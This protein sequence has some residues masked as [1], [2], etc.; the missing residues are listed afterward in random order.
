MTKENNDDRSKLPQ[1]LLD[2][3][4][5]IG[6][7]VLNFRRA[8]VKEYKGQ[9]YVERVLI[10]VEEDGELKVN[11][12]DYE[13]TK[14]EA[15][16]I[17]AELKECDF[18]RHVH[19]T[20]AAAKAFIAAA[21]KA[22]AKD[23]EEYFLLR[24]RSSAKITMI[25]ERHYKEDGTKIFIPHTLW[26]DNK[27]RSMECSGKLPFWKPREKSG[28]HKLMVHEGGKPARYID[29]LCNDPSP[30][31]KL[32][33]EHHPWT[34][35]LA[36]YEHW[37]M[38]G[39][40]LAAQRS[41]YKEIRT[42][43]FQEIVYV[44]DNDW[45][46][47]KAIKDF[48]ANYGGSMK[49][50]N[51][52]DRFKESFD[53]ADPLPED[54]FKII[55]VNDEERRYWIGPP[56]HRFLIGA[57]TATEIVP[58]PSGKGRSVAVLRDIFAQEWHHT[59]SPEVFIHRS[60]PN[61]LMN[62]AEFNSY[63][64]PFSDVDDVARLLRADFPNK[65]R[66]MHYLPGAPAGRYG[67]NHLGQFFNTY[68]E[69]PI[70][71]IKKRRKNDT[72]P[73]FDFLEMF[74][75]EESDRIEVMRWCATLLARPAIRMTYG[76]LLV[77]EMQGVGK[78]T[79][80]EKILAPLVGIDNV[81]FPS[82]QDIVESQFNSWIAHRRLAVVHEIYQGQSSRA[83]N[84]V[85]SII[86]DHYITVNKKH[87]PTYEIE[88]WMHIVACSN[89]LR[90]LKLAF[91]DRRW[92]VPRITEEQ[93]GIEYWLDLNEW[94]E[95]RNGLEII[96]AW[97]NEWL[98][99]ARP[100]MPGANAPD[101]AAKREMIEESMSPG[102]VLVADLL[103]RWKL[104]NEGKPGVFTTDIA[105]V[106]Y[107]KNALYNGKH[108]DR[109]ERPGTIRKLAKTRGWFIGTERSP[110]FTEH[111]ERA[112][113]LATKEALSKR[114]PEALREEGWEPLEMPM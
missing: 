48:S 64:R 14:E 86:T 43:Q 18:P 31:A 85:K 108:N 46:G 107:I 104:E 33:R 56:L 36:G 22:N 88:N 28:K 26:S 113:I 69:P 94:L 7:E 62:A 17:K 32:A 96:L 24:S 68:C 10:K 49:A 23:G 51:F 84:R 54:L 70:K 53:L 9:Y 114:H 4:R 90:A 35:E 109:L 1:A 97:A 19:A 61:R 60:W 11:R 98:L 25:Q 110:I 83:Y 106:N 76:L 3:Y 2:Y 82:E 73:W 20:E 103:D 52:D 6:A 72:Q 75:P 100:V 39:G 99:D 79:L 95:K 42:E 37:G 13:P 105:L 47:R 44:G 5:R 15:A 74:I 29:W 89:S 38:I 57:T 27:W 71:P 66:I 40:A 67:T 41:D 77:S 80:G 78:G 91:D 111:G 81:S 30:E 87:M 101:S 58:N 63:V 21:A 55:I 50:I 92:Y 8:M 12:K 16:A 45:P 102:M 65:S 59:V 112:R 93:Q 34:E